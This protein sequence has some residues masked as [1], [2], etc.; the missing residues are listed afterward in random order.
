MRRLVILLGCC[1][2]LVSC[3]QDKPGALPGY[4]E[5]EYTRIAAPIAGRLVQLAVEKGADIQKDAPL[6]VLEADSEKA[7]LDEAQARLLRSTAQAAD[8]AK[9]KRR[10]EIAVLEAQLSAA[11][12]SL[13]LAQSDF[14]RQTELARA[15]FTSGANLEALQT[16]VRAEEAKVREMAAQLKVARLAARDDTRVA[17]AADISAAKAQI[18][19]NRWR[20]EQKTVL[21]PAAARVDDT[22]YRVGEWV[23]AGAPVVSLLTPSAIKLRFFV[24]QDRLS[25]FPVGQKLAVGCDGCKP[26]GARV[27]YVAKS[28]EFTPP[29]IYSRENRAKLVFMVEAKPDNEQGLAPGQPVDI[30]LDGQP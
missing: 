9:G 13:A 5:A 14:K 27:S 17:A 3:Q 18:A 22:L 6:F 24:P 20:L 1:A 11:Q 25:Q 8:L 28:A 23:P 7:A 19:Q 29:V 15:G 16:R 30:R 10:E 2:M 4:A 21:S 12:S 26:F